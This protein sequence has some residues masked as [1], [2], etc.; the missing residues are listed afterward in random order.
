MTRF[1]GCGTAL[2]TPFTTDGAVDYPALRALVDWQIAE[3][4]DFLVVCGSTGEA[5]TLDTAERERVVAAVTE[6]AAGRVPV[7][8]GATSNDTAFAVDETRR[9]CRIGIDYVLS[10]TPYYNRPSQDGLYRHFMA[11]ADASSKPIC[12]YNV[13]G[14]TAVNLHPATALKLATHTNVMGIKEASGDL[15]QVMEILRQR[16]AG[17]AVLSG[18]DWLTMPVIGAGGDGLVSVVSNQV[19][20]AM[21]ALVHLLL[22]GDLEKARSWHYRLMPLM[23][24]NFLET[25]PAPAKAALHLMG[26]IHDVLRLPLLPVSDATREALRTALRTAGVADV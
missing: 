16:P 3:G 19:P 24:A 10:A 17:F 25:N 22:S 9:M 18:D 14:R 12:L 7:M 23:D 5:Q 26:R 6:V 2:V 11:V 20:A 1:Q 15:K 8:A 13:P 4:I 21:T